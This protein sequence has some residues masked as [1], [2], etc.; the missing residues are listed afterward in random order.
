MKVIQIS[1]LHLVAA[2]E[3]A[4]LD[5]LRRLRA[6]IDDIN[7]GFPDADFV[8]VTGDLAD[9]GEPAAYALL[10][11]E[12]RRLKPRFGLTLGNHD[13]RDAFRAVFG[14]A[15][16]AQESVDL[17]GG[18]LLLLDTLDPG[19]VGGVLC[20]ERLSWLDGQLAG[21]RPT[22]LFMHH[23][24]VDVHL[25][26]L[27]R[28]RLADADAL[29][30]VLARHGNVRHIFAGHVHRQISGSWHGVPFSILRSTNHQ[31]A[32]RLMQ[33]EFAVSYEPPHY[34]VILADAAGVVVHTREFTEQPGRAA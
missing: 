1:D 18:R 27:D 4:G 29:R 11:A 26:V 13:S 16:F 28:I 19:K 32:L 9:R 14:G 5:P 12:L 17:D 2:G 8:A 7:D 23:P 31:T 33:D 34:A 24:P 10:A 6:A 21:G 30:A 3:V 22:L 25:P 15:G 20:A